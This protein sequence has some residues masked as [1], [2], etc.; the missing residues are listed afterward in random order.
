MKQYFTKRLVSGLI[1]GC[2][3][4]SVGAVAFAHDGQQEFIPGPSM[5]HRMPNPEDREKHMKIFM[6]KLLNDSIITQEQ[7][8][9][10]IS[11][12]KEKD[13]QRKTEMEKTR[14]MTPEE[15]D[16][17]FKEKFNQRPDMIKEL[18][19]AAD[20]SDEQA[21]AVDDTLRPPHRPGPE[22][23]PCGPCGPCCPKLPTP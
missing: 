5:N 2:L 17:F 4:L 18:K 6:D 19:D 23:G 14:F 13:D 9:K 8:A 22:G 20:L 16:A 1:L 21:K 12:F 3:A 15:R 7:A 11:F 10:L